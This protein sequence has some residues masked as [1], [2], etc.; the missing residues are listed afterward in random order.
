ARPDRAPNARAPRP[1]PRGGRVPRSRNPRLHRL[2][3]AGSGDGARRPA[4]A[5]ACELTA[6]RIGTRSSRLAM[7]QA[8]M[9]AAA[10]CE[11]GQEVVIVPLSTQGDRDARRTFAEIGGRGTFSSGLDGA[12]GDG[13]IYVGG[14]AAQ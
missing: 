13:R 7:A 11:L 3:R 2:G 6:L 9:A 5:G 14:R 12:L 8:H 1:R 10:L 4:R